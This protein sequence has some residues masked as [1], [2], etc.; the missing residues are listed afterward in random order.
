MGKVL[1]GIRNVYVAKLNEDENGNITYETPFAVAGATGFSPEP[2]GDTT[3]FYADDK[4]YFRK[5]K[6]NGYEGELTLA[7]TPQE[8]LTQILGRTVDSN[9]AVIET[10]DDT[11]S[12]FALLFEGEGDPTNRRYV[13]WDCTTTRPSR[14][15][16]TTEDSIEVGTDSLTI[17]IAP[18]SSDNA[19]GGYIEKTEVNTAIY[20]SWFSQVYEKN[21]IASV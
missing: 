13:Y 10:A 19:V 12:R 16:A 18:R 20:N 4:I 15:H 9:G 6:N 11:F 3:V 17:T 1:Y 14:E 5:D 7:V 21:Q 8:F 2:Q